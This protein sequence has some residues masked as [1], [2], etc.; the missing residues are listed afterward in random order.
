MSIQPLPPDVV[1]QIR[2]SITITSLNQV[3][4]ELIMNSLDAGAT[5]LDVNIDYSRGGCIVEDD[6]LGIFPSEF[7]SDG[8]LGKLH[9][10]SKFNSQSPVHGGRGIFLAAL[11]AMA[12]F[13]ITS[14]HHNHRSHNALTMHK[15]EVVSRQ[16]PTPTQQDVTNAAHGTRVTVRDLFGNM[17]VRVKQRAILAEKQRG[18]LR[19][20][21]ELRRDIISLLLAWPKNVSLTMR[22]SESNYK[23]VIR[24][25]ATISEPKTSVDSVCRILSQASFISHGEKC[26]WV[27]VGASTLNLRICGALSLRPNATKNVQFL[28]L[29]ILPITVSDGRNLLYDEINRLFSN[30]AFGADEDIER[31]DR[32]NRQGMERI[33]PHRQ[34]QFTKKELRGIKKGV[35]RWPMFCI[36]IQLLETGTSQVQFDDVSDNKG[37]ILSMVIELLQTMILEFL[38]KHHFRPKPVRPKPVRTHRARNLSEE[39][40]RPSLPSSPM[41]CSPRHGVYSSRSAKI[42]GPSTP[43]RKRYSSI[44]KT[45]L[46]ALGTNVRIPSFRKGRIAS[47]SPFD[48]WSRVK[49]GAMLSRSS[50]PKEIALVEGCKIAR[51][52]TSPPRASNFP[53]PEASTRS[54][55]DS[56]KAFRPL[57]SK[58]GKI[59]RA[60]FDDVDAVRPR[61]GAFQA[62]LPTPPAPNRPPVDQYQDSDVHDD[63]VVY[64]N[65]ITK[66]ESLVNQRTGLTMKSNSVLS[67]KRISQPSLE[68][69]RIIP[70][71]EGPSPWM[72]DLLSRWDNP[73]FQTTEPSIPQISFKGHGATTPHIPYGRHHHCSQIH[74]DRAFQCAS[75]GISGRVSK[76]A[77]TRAEVIC[78]VDK[79]FILVKVQNSASPAQDDDSTLILIDQ[80]AADERIRVEA[81]IQELVTVPST[82]SDTDPAST[83]LTTRLEKPLDFE[84]SSKEIEL[85]DIHRAHFANWGILYT[86]PAHKTKST[87]QGVTVFS[88]PPGILER[89]KLDPGLL[90]ELMRTEVYKIPCPAQPLTLSCPSP[91]G[92][93]WVGRIHGCPQG[94]LD[95]LSSRACR[96]AIMF[97]DV[98]TKRQ[99]QALVE[100]LSVCAF[101]FVCAHGR[102]SLVPIVGV[103]SDGGREAGSMERKMEG[104]FG[105]SFRR[106]K[107]AMS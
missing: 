77:L 8:H 66:I 89:C 1:A 100:R 13:S 20:W 58:D 101:P 71:T 27:R 81:L 60:P 49:Q 94:I 67:R 41:P 103:G 61:T 2:S 104:G 25:P 80:H 39:L 69:T 40:N 79:K 37:Q 86:F 105:K 52:S 76:D 82:E 99:C 3:V 26:S 36:N 73:V 17:P 15:S 63:V 56:M 51:P 92:G 38:T 65:P 74:V 9:H 12:V 64:I 93:D 30:S 11:S 19:D 87:T 78:Q 47:D 55:S 107:E 34:D 23:M 84:L 46:D 32:I 33:D 18:H 98:L 7:G 106:W 96:S 21:E 75:S 24:V 72:M 54:T 102:P 4:C 31:R 6:G 35:D 97:N 43:Q 50:T 28:S 85:L 91:G 57:I 42:T 68:P 45:P 59:I 29:G 48:T 70:M 44:T 16:I 10:S 90:I 53:P 88:L 83:I 22:E 14:H 5:K 95:M 62:P